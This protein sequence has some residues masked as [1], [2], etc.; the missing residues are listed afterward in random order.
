[1]RHR[2]IGA[3][4]LLAAALFAFPE[5]VQDIR[6]LKGALLERARGE[7]LQAILCFHAGEEKIEAVAR[8]QAQPA[9]ASRIGGAKFAPAAAR[10]AGARGPAASGNEADAPR[11]EAA[12]PYELAE[13][14]AG[15]APASLPLPT[16]ADVIV[17]AAM[18]ARTAAPTELAAARLI[19]ALGSTFLPVSAAAAWGGEAAAPHSQRLA[20][21]PRPAAALSASR[22]DE[23]AVLHRLK[24]EDVL[25]GALL[26]EAELER[27]LNSR[28]RVWSVKVQRQGKAA[29]P[30][31]EAPPPPQQAAC[32][33]EKQAA[34]SSH[35][36]GA[37]WEE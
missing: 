27:L 2:S 25:K 6:S 16:A 11:V 7:L 30:A 37:S 35:W 21:L 3:F 5:A 13:L 1:M 17:E 9:L 19:P 18:E 23:A 26:D 28:K 34:D 24:A 36:A 8:R 31:V 20:P 33:D 32:D 12:E 22:A 14:F 10:K 15:E 29:P 4:I